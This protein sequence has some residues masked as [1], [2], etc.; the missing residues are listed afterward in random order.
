VR[1]GA[2]GTWSAS[3]GTLIKAR[4]KFVLFQAFG[5]LLAYE[6]VY[7]NT[8]FEGER[9]NILPTGLLSSFNGQTGGT[10]PNLNVYNTAGVTSPVLDAS[11][12]PRF[13]IIGGDQVVGPGSPIA[14]VSRG[15]P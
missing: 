12:N 14:R 6:G 7:G 3:G 9:S 13:L 2:V 8:N 15:G 1:N 10:I 4:S 11:N 5:Q